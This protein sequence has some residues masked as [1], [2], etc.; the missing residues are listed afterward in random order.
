MYKVALELTKNCNLQC[1][2]CYQTHSLEKMDMQVAK[3]AVDLGFKNAR[4]LQMKEVLISFFGGEP[5]LRFKD[6]VQLTLYAQCVAVSNNFEVSFEITTNG[7]LFSSK[8]INFL[9]ENKF[10]L[11]VSLD[12]IP[13]YHDLNRITKSQQKSYE[14]I[15]RNLNLIMLYQQKVNM[16]VQVSMVITKNNYKELSSNIEHLFSLGFRMFDTALNFKESWADS[17]LLKVKEGLEKVVDMYFRKAKEGRA[18]AWTFIDNGIRPQMRQ[19]TNYYCGAGITSMFV[20]TSGEIYPCF[21]CF[22]DEAKIGSIELGLVENKVKQFRDYKRNLKNECK[23]CEIRSVCPAPDCIMINLEYSGDYHTVPSLFC[24]M[25]QI[26]Y[27]LTNRLH[28]DK[29]WKELISKS[30]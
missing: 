27:E 5:L 6:I 26:R 18:F 10:C 24:K 15:I 11:K 1:E 9:M 17:E 12:G 23:E 20:R 21:A 16:L 30:Q 28:I 25:A 2:Y 3:S 13:Y 22:Q 29:E 14:L 7:T 8:I 4:S 19:R